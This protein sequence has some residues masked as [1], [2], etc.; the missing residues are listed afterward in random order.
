MNEFEQTPKDFLAE[1][2]NF[3]KTD[4]TESKKTAISEEDILIGLDENSDIDGDVSDF[5]VD[6][7]E[8]KESY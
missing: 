6:T 8:E 5:E 4:K 2:D 3:E 1:E 7:G